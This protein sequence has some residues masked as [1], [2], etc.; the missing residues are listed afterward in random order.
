MFAYIKFL[1]DLPE[2]SHR[3]AGFCHHKRHRD[4]SSLL[5]KYCGETLWSRRLAW[6]DQWSRYKQSL[7]YYHMEQFSDVATDLKRLQENL[8]LLPAASWAHEAEKQVSLL[9]V[10]CWAL[11]HVRR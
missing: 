11:R 4:P 7:G 6:T 8:T 2:F 10:D 9:L 5:R 3:F 1:L